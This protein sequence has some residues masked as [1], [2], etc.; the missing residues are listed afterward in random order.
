MKKRRKLQSKFFLAM[1]N[2]KNPLKHGSE[3]DKHIEN[4]FTTLKFA[5]QSMTLC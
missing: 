5:I 2:D 3:I 4:L 1:L